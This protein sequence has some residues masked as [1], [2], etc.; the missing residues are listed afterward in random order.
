MP[1]LCKFMLWTTLTATG[2]VRLSAHLPFPVGLSAWWQ[3]AGDSFWHFGKQLKT[4]FNQSHLANN[5]LNA[6]AN[7]MATIYGDSEWKFKIHVS[8][9][10]NRRMLQLTVSMCVCVRWSA[11]T[12]FVLCQ[13][14]IECDD[15][16]QIDSQQHLQTRAAAEDDKRQ[17]NAGA[18][19]S[20][21][22]CSLP[23]YTL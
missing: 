17:T 1:P 13:V 12:P 14:T 8:K 19:Q 20:V 11:S 5:F 7:A 18:A 9:I 10:N 16:C 3:G 4:C 21:N 23:I 15:F 6:L 22:F 2:P